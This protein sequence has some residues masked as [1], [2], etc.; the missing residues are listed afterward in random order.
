MFDFSKCENAFC[1]RREYTSTN[2]DAQHAHTLTSMNIRIQILPYEDLRKTVPARFKIDKVTT[3][4][5][6]C[7]TE[8][9]RHR[10]TFLFVIKFLKAHL[11]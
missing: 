4:V 11:A 5:Y 6:I 9:S 1:G 7:W 2:A 10:L 8:V 3:G